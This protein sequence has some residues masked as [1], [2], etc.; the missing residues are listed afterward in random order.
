[1]LKAASFLQEYL[2]AQ[3]QH[4]RLHQKLACSIHIPERCKNDCEQFQIYIFRELHCHS[5]GLSRI[6][7]S[8]LTLTASSLRLWCENDAVIFVFAAPKA[9][10]IFSVTPPKAEDHPPDIKYTV[11]DN[12]IPYNKNCFAFLGPKIA[13]NFIF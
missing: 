12:G 11:W 7:L 4:Y 3:S 13:L 6:L 5:L 2:A 1:M 9:V 8:F 10:P